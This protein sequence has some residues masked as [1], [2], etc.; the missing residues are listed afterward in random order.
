[1][2]QRRRALVLGLVAAVVISA[3]LFQR[4]IRTEWHK[5]RLQASK[6]KKRHF[7]SLG[8]TGAD[9]FWMELTGQAVS[10]EVFERTIRQHEDALVNLGFL[11]REVYAPTNS[12][13]PALGDPRYD[14]TIQQ[15]K[16]ECPWYSSRELSPTNLVVTACS[17]GMAKWRKTAEQ[18]GLKKKARC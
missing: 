2:K 9:K 3:I 7:M 16:S 1:M 5:W 15:L 11:L 18:F 6:E 17:S 4:P 8:I 10:L 13:M 14:Q 12:V